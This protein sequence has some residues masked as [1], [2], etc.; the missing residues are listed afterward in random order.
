MKPN[1]K[2]RTAL[3]RKRAKNGIRQPQKIDSNV[4]EL[5]WLSDTSTKDQR[6]RTKQ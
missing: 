6:R 4:N 3:V 2:R 5:E 1:R